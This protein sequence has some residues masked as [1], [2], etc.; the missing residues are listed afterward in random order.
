MK[1]KVSMIKNKISFYDDFKCIASKCSD[2]CCEG[3][4]VYIDKES[5]KKYRTCNLKIGEKI[6]DELKKDEYG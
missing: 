4:D 3:W 1:K 5:V 6:R 2:S